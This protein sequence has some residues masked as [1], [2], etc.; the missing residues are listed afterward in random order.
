[1]FDAINCHT[2]FTQRSAS[3]LVIVRTYCFNTL[4][5]VTC[6]FKTIHKVKRCYFFFLL[7]TVIRTNHYVSEPEVLTFLANFGVKIL[8]YCDP[9]HLGLHDFVIGL[10]NLAAYI[11][12]ICR[13][14]FFP[15]VEFQR[16]SMIAY[17]D[18]C[19]R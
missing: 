18:Y 13:V 1:M 17:L 4:Y 2:T 19:L 10:S 11:F 3:W 9:K 7:I 16:K 8:N 14:N 6:V 12:C 5:I 15:S